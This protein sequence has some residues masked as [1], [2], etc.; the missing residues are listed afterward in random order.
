VYT[1]RHVYFVK[2]VFPFFSGLSGFGSFGADPRA[3][4]LGAMRGGDPRWSHLPGAFCRRQGSQLPPP[5][6]SRTEPLGP[7]LQEMC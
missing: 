1:S 7:L 2:T 3:L 5:R 4:L 6:S